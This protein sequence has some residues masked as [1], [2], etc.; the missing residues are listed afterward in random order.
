MNLITTKPRMLELFACEGGATAG[1]KNA[2][3]FVTAI[4][5]DHNRLSYNPADQRSVTNAFDYFDKFHMN[6]QAHHSSPPC[7][8][9]T[10]GNAMNDVSDKWPDLIPVVRE[11]YS[12][13]DT[14][15]VIENVSQ[16]R[17][18]MKNP[19]E[20]CGCMF[21]LTA[22]DDDGVRLHLQRI[23]LFESNFELDSP[24][25]H[26]HPRGIQWAGVYGGARRDKHEARYIRKG[27][28]VPPSKDVCAALLGITHNMTWGG[29]KE[30]LPPVYT[31]YVGSKM[32][33]LL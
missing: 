7:Q 16:A 18:A 23:R 2:G 22:I 31:E 20:L 4:D 13:L 15:W 32:L 8:F 19:T 30:S 26:N 25:P 29:L 14:P 3:F 10:R 17:W 11:M 27:G 24:R 5:N 12:S 9:Y 28:Y 33:E 21:D 6:Y 1:Y